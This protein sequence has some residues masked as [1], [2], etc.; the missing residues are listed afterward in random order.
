VDA[1]GPGRGAPRT[2]DGPPLTLGARWSALRLAVTV[3]GSFLAAVVVSTAIAVALGIGRR[4]AQ[5]RSAEE[6][7]FLALLSDGALLVALAL[8]GRRLLALRAADLGLRRP[9]LGSLGFAASAAGGLWLLS[10]LANILQI[11]AFGP[12][13]QSLIVS[14]GAHTGPVALFLDL[15]TGAVVAPFAEEI[16]FR[17]L[18]FGGLAQRMPVAAAATASALLFALSHG[19]GVVVPIFVLGLGLAYVY[20]RAGTIWAPMVTHGLVNAVSLLLVFAGP[21]A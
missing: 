19:L 8:L 11:R 3:I 6:I 17:G 20:T 14:V 5:Q 2:E 1:D 16:L 12:N 13:P 7:L 4:A 18:I 21:K 9:S 10:I 15:V